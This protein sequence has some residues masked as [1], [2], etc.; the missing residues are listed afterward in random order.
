MQSEKQG[1]KTNWEKVDAALEAYRSTIRLNASQLIRQHRQHTFSFQPFSKKQSQVLT[2]W[3]DTSP[4]KDY[5][6]LIADGSIRSGKTLSMS[7]SF[8]FWAMTAFDGHNFAICG[9]TI[10]SLRRNVIIWLKMMLRSRGYTVH[11]RRTDNLLLMRRGE[12][13]NFFYLFGGR[14]ERSQDLIQGITLAGVLFDEVALMPESFV[15]QATARCSVEGSKWW[16]NCNPQGPQHWFYK[17]WI[18]RCRTHG[19]L[20]LHFTMDDNLSLS[21]EIKER[22]QRQYTGVFYRRY[23][24]GEWCLAEGLIYP[25]LP[26]AVIPTEDRRYTQYQIAV[27]YGTYNPACFGLFGLCDGVWYLVKEYYH[28]GRD[29][30][31]PKTDAE[32]YNDLVDFIGNRRIVRIL[33]DPSA[34]SFITLIERKGRFSVRGADNAVIEGIGHTST[35]LHNGRLKINDCCER[36]I[37]EAG[38]YSWDDKSGADKPKKE[39]DHAMDMLRYFVNYNQRE[40]LPR[41]LSQGNR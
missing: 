37:E 25:H 26:K 1:V 2:W 15:N 11:E 21:Q 28:S 5:N 8:V 34:S 12:T 22:Y 39:S 10:G 3:C 20:Y 41:A 19:L 31:R 29:T 40:L 27:D 4:V 35:A 32:Y 7:L 14:D 18:K 23:V 38:A 24:M 33:V 13:L 16:F 17:K 9:K 6:G 36:T 30:K